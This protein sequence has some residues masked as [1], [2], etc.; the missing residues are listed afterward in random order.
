M[1]KKQKRSRAVLTAALLVAGAAGVLLT[2]CK[3]TERKEDS[4]VESSVRESAEPEVP[5]EL[6]GDNGVQE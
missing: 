4:A 1:R 5:E 3:T 2:G 6:I